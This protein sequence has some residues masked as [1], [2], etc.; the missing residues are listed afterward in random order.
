MNGVLNVEGGTQLSNIGGSNTIFSTTKRGRGLSLYKET[1]SKGPTLPNGNGAFIAT[2]GSEWEIVDG[3]SGHL[4]SGPS[5]WSIYCN[6]NSSPENR[7]KQC[8][9]KQLSNIHSNENQNWRQ[10]NAIGTELVFKQAQATAWDDYSITLKMR[11]NDDD[12][13]GVNFRR[14]D[15]NNYYTFEMG[16]E[17][18]SRRLKKTVGGVTTILK[19]VYPSS[20]QSSASPTVCG[21]EN[22]EKS[23]VKNNWYNIEIKAVQDRLQVSVGEC[24]SGWDSDCSKNEQVFDVKDSDAEDDGVLRRGSISLRSASNDY[25]EWRELQVDSMSLGSG[26]SG[27]KP[28][29]TGGGFYGS[30]TFTT[31]LYKT[32]DSTSSADHDQSIIGDVL[33]IDSSTG[34]FFMKQIGADIDS[35]YGWDLVAQESHD[36]K[37][38]LVMLGNAFGTTS[39]A[40]FNTGVSKVHGTDYD[41]VAITW[42]CPESAT[43]CATTPENTCTTSK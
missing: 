9:V 14:V 13:V 21:L 42:C 32:S 2:Y 22:S 38:E 31:W 4:Q 20:C 35:T 11:S 19:E 25:A 16:V 29:I 15:A 7:F 30:F 12:W 40:S 8:S 43:T 18:A 28:L 1:W 23:Y 5:S 27:T 41:E 37:Q 3:V 26:I 33:R 17:I 10:M 24:G 39:D 6:S 34:N 36:S